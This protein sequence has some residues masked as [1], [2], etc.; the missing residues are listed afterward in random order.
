MIVVIIIDL[1]DFAKKVYKNGWLYVIVSLRLRSLGR[2]N[3]MRP[4]NPL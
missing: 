3:S 1:D 4:E 2:R